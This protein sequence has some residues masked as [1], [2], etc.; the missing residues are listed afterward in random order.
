ML[1]E[2]YLIVVYFDDLFSLYFNK[3]FYKFKAKKNT[4]YHTTIG[5]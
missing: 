3:Y 1:I 5:K 4:L 2:W